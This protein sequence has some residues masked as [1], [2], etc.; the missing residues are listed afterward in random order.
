MGGRA[1]VVKN[2][3]AP[4]IRKGSCFFISPNDCLTNRQK[5]KNLLLSFD[6]ICKCIGIFSFFNVFPKNSV[7]FSIDIPL[8]CSICFKKIRQLSRPEFT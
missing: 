2:A 8:Y 4:A 7:Y 5:N 1:N 3:V 6:F